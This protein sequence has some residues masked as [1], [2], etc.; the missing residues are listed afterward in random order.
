MDNFRKEVKQL[1]TEDIMLILEDQ[2]DLYSAE[3]LNILRT[4]LN[5]RPSLEEQYRIEEEERAYAEMQE[6]IEK[7]RAAFHAKIENLRNEGRD[8]YY[9]YMTVSLVD[10]DSGALE[11]SQVA[12]ILN[13]HALNGWRLVSAYSN[14]LG[15]N[16]TSGGIG[17]F[18][19][20]KNATID[21]HVLILE[22]FIKI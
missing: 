8:G 4:E 19:T 17:G 9:Q 5:S 11:P 7:N 1:S 15:H 13:Y 22:R 14:E 6:E 18:S 21:Q 10:D 20:G 16:T 12:D 2:Q 3:E